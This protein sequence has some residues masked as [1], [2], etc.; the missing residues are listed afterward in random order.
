MEGDESPGCQPEAG[1][2]NPQKRFQKARFILLSN[3]IQ[4]LYS[5]IVFLNVY[6][7]VHF[8]ADYCLI[9]EYTGS[10]GHNTQVTESWKLISLTSRYSSK[11][12]CFF[13]AFFGVFAHFCMVL[14]IF[15]TYVY[16]FQIYSENRNLSAIF[17]KIKNLS[18]TESL[19]VL[20]PF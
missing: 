16:S 9:S 11:G 18:V 6:G 2:R 20:S 19:L 4:K 12:F 7:R 10:F 3:F 17:L 8:I 5:E 13:N 15:C 14:S 1:K